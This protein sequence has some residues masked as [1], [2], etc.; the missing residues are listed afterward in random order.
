MRSSSSWRRAV[1]ANHPSSGWWRLPSSSEIDHQRED[2]L[3]AVEPGQRPRVGQQ[4]RGVEH[5]TAGGA[6]GHGCSLAGAAPHPL[7]RWAGRPWRDPRATR[8]TAPTGS[9][10]AG[11]R[12]SQVRALFEHRPA[13]VPEGTSRR[14]GGRKGLSSTN[15]GLPGGPHR[16]RPATADDIGGRPR[17]VN[18][19]TDRSS[20]RS[21]RFNTSAYRS[22][23]IR[24]RPSKLK[25]PSV[26]V[27]PRSASA[28][29]SRQA[30]EVLARRGRR[31]PAEPRAHHAEPST[32]A[33][34]CVRHSGRASASTTRRA[35][36]VVEQQP[37]P[38]MC[39]AASTPPA[40]GRP[41]PCSSSAA[42]SRTRRRAARSGVQPLGERDRPCRRRPCARTLLAHGPHPAPTAVVERALGEALGHARSAGNRH[43]H[44]E[45]GASRARRR[46]RRGCTRRGGRGR[47]RAREA[48]ATGLRRPRARVDPHDRAV[49]AGVGVQG[50][51][52]GVV[53]D[54]T[55]T[56]SAGGSP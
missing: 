43:G 39:P 11:C 51:P 18:S 12:P 8:R 48:A 38:Q 3:V 27:R 49:E 34:T 22:S 31:R 30:A 5:V 29:R 50:A 55:A 7:L 17:A 2:H 10:R 13:A 9:A 40:V 28:R 15:Q 21:P 54:A 16:L 33:T 46:A 25:Q 56:A 36:S 1:R 26:L 19:N 41:P 32:E 6:V 45:L 37:S 47:S 52:R 53:D 4:D 20:R 35:R 14:S 42:S 44:A 23:L 24:Y